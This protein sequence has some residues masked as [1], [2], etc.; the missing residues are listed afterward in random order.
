MRS[1]I[2][3]TYNICVKGMAVNFPYVFLIKYLNY[4]VYIKDY[5]N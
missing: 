5:I 3:I 4:P 2:L 1:A